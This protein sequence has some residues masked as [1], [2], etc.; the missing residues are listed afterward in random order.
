MTHRPRPSRVLGYVRVSGLAQAQHGTSLDEQQAEI[1]RY[2]A[3]HKYP[4]PELYVEQESGAAGPE[5]RREL[6]RL[7]AAAARGDLV[8]VTALDRW[9]RDLPYAVESIRK[10]QARGVAW[11]AIRDALDPSTDVGQLQ[12]GYLAVGA[13][14]ERRRTR[15]RTVD[16][17]NALVRQGLWPYSHPPVGYRFAG[18]RRLEP[19][20]EVAPM[21]R[22][23]FEQ[24]T[25]GLGL[26]A[27]E[28]EGRRRWPGWLWSGPR[29]SLILRSRNVLGEIRACSAEGWTRG[30]HEPLVSVD[31]FE[32]AQAAIEQRRG[33]GPPPQGAEQSAALLLVGFARCAVCGRR[34]SPMFNGRVGAGGY[35]VCAGKRKRERCVG[36]GYRQAAPIDA[37]VAALVEARL[38]ELRGELAKPPA[39]A[40]RTPVD[41]LARKRAAL[42]ARRERAVGLAVEGKISDADLARQ[43]GKIDEAA[44]ALDRQEREAVR[45]TRAAAPAARRKVLGSVETIRRAWG[46]ASVAQRRMVL[47]QLAHEVRLSASDPVIVWRTLEEL[48]E[49]AG[50]V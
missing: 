22:W 21:L 7:L 24:C 8:L 15:Q 31:L 28:V 40:P 10:L 13:D 20:P 39:A 38:V 23:A 42:T 1:T 49:Q 11:F 17:R 25:A 43:L 36:W 18:A 5:V 27:I 30:Q 47:R 44:A 45:V 33:D 26:R 12:L 32:R 41:D 16:G 3:A 9:S 19:D 2:C 14:H 50:V 34:C 37:A 48:A 6:G 4:A 29:L 35:Y 46:A